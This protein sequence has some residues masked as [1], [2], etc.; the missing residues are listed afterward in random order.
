[1]H[2][3]KTGKRGYPDYLSNIV[4]EAREEFIDGKYLSSVIMSSMSVE[5]V[6]I[7]E[8]QRRGK[9]AAG[10]SKRIEMGKELGLPVDELFD[11]NEDV[12]CPKDSL[13]V[14]RRNAVAHGDMH[15]VPHRKGPFE[16]KLPLE[17]FMPFRFP[18]APID[19]LDQ[20]SKAM[21]FLIRWRTRRN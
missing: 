1:M 6:L 2:D 21:R 12:N 8:L 11:K 9:R 3:L 4:E 5:W 10:L 20:L 13:F 17:V 19:S 15:G 7:S 16:S 18:I 14:K